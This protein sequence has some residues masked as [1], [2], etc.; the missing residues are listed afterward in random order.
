MGKDRPYNDEAIPRLEPNLRTPILA[1]RVVELLHFTELRANILF[2]LNKFA[3]V[4]AEIHRTEGGVH[5]RSG[6]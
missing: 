5:P 1:G 3:R 4:S 2:C 6:V